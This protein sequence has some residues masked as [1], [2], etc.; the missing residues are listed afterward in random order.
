MKP[1]GGLREL[2]GFSGGEVGVRKDVQWSSGARRCDWED[3]TE[4]ELEEEEEE[5]DEGDGIWDVVP[6]MEDEG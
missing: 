4:S 1:I 5:W 2:Y 6:E 3:P